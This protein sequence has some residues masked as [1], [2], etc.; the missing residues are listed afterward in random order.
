MK[1]RLSLLVLLL[2]TLIIISGCNG[3]G[4]LKVVVYD[5]QQNPVNDVYVGIYKSD[6][7]QRLRFAY[8]RR[9][10]VEF[11]GLESGVY[12]IRIIS[13][14]QKKEMKLR[15]NNQEDRYLK[16]NLNN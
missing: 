12:Y 3:K 4:N 6:F 7:N 5:Q 15:I 16:V 2:I 8:T 1:K 13:P 14:G 10:E 9:G 11:A